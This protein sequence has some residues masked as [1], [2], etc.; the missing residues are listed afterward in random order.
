[1]IREQKIWFKTFEKNIFKNLFR[2]R[3]MSRITP[4][5]SS[6]G[7][8]RTLEGT[9]TTSALFHKLVQKPSWELRAVSHNTSILLSQ[10]TASTQAG[11]IT[12]TFER[13]E[14]LLERKWREGVNKVDRTHLQGR[15]E[16]DLTQNK[17]RSNENQQ[18]KL[19]CSL[20]QRFERKCF[21]ETHLSFLS[22][23]F[24]TNPAEN[25]PV[26]SHRGEKTHAGLNIVVFFI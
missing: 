5:T 26:P 11:G 24:P 18:N 15:N 23:G 16:G 13:Q 10:T 4:W 2:L 1:M 12:I 21:L 17:Q 25:L 19:V 7:L 8:K 14:K 6:N 20:N 22:T 3:H 9:R